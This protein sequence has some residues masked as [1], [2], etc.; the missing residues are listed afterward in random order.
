M[1]KRSLVYMLDIASFTVKKS[2]EPLLYFPRNI[3]ICSQ[4]NIYSKKNF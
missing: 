4:M 2:Q 3:F 1:F